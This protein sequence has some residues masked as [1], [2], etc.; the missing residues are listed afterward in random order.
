MT[1]VMK[2]TW[3]AGP[4]PAHTPRTVPLP[5]RRSRSEGGVRAGGR[6][7]RTY[8][9]IGGLRWGYGRGL[10][11]AVAGGREVGPSGGERANERESERTR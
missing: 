2:S 9:Q 11:A 1:R 10:E 7:G 8:W 4:E 3:P 6:T 5:T